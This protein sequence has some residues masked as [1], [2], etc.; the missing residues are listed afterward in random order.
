M[1]VLFNTILPYNETEKNTLIGFGER[2]ALGARCTEIFKVMIDLRMRCTIF[3]LLVD[4]LANWIWGQII[5]WSFIW[6][7]KYEFHA[8]AHVKANCITP[9]G[10]T[11][12]NGH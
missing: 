12:L 4:Q 5:F 10:H 11:Q 6:L 2:V 1:G 9:G 3:F 7:K 8:L